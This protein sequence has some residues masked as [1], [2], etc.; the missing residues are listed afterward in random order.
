MKFSLLFLLSII[1]IVLDQTTKMWLQHV[2]YT[3]LIPPLLSLRSTTNTGIAFSIPLQGMLLIVVTI[4]VIVMGGLYFIRNVEMC[5]PL[6]LVIGGF[7]LGGALG[8]LI[9]RVWR[10][11]VIDFIEL[12]IIPI[13]NLADTFIFL[14]AVLFVL[15]YKR[16]QLKK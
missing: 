12:W 15:Y 11:F 8:N 14:G 5:H 10:G 6:S 1:I 4:T 2:A 7:L 9:D 3:P 16:I 13:F